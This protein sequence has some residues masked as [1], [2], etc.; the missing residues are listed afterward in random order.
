MVECRQDMNE[1]IWMKKPKV[2][3]TRKIPD[4]LLEPFKE[5]LDFAMWSSENT[6]VPEEVLYEE[7]KHAD[8]LLTLLTE[9]I[10]REF[11]DNASHLKIIANMAV[12]Y[13][14]ID[15][16]A[17][18]EKEIIVT[19]TP[20]V[21]T[22]TTADLTF[23]LLMATA[24]RLIEATNCIYED[25]W[26]DWSPFMLAGTDIY[27]K[28]IGIVGLGRI[29]EAVARRAKGFKMDILYHNRNRNERGEKE[30]G[31]YYASFDELLQQSDFVVSLVPLS[32]QTEN[33]FDKE[34]FLKM[35]QS[36]IFINASRG[37][38]VDEK[39]LYEALKSRTIRAAGLDVFKEEPISSAHP[40]A[41]L[42]NAVLLPHIGS[43]SKETRE[44]MLTLCLKNLQLIFQGKPPK[45]PV[46]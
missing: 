28:K 5:E 26:G 44:N 13:D 21:L 17:A 11:L 39:A 18:A 37:G 3:I 35:K 29:G 24:R 34:A 30:L 7:V 38:V 36:A 41:E 15:I 20:D 40:L 16:D 14:N 10:D 22:E 19:N 45:T 42:D 32:K 31:A 33:L 27:A 4:Y 2:Y 12:G 23:A 6:P 43:A 46:Q 1:V 25:K 8:G 9:K